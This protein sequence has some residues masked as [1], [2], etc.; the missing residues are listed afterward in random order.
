MLTFV[1]KCAREAQRGAVRSKM[2]AND[3]LEVLCSV[4]Q[5][6]ERLGVSH[7]EG[8]AKFIADPAQKSAAQ[9]RLKSASDPFRKT[10]ANLYKK[11]PSGPRR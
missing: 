3:V 4:V 1:E 6:Y 9:S 10:P 7:S 11:R 2:G 5:E 8:R